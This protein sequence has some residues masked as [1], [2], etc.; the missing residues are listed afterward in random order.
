MPYVFSAGNLDGNQLNQG[1]ELS[2]TLP[3][4]LG[5]NPLGKYT[6]SPF[7]LLYP[8]PPKY[9]DLKRLGES[10]WSYQFSLETGYLATSGDTNSASFTEYG[11]WDEAPILNRYSFALENPQKA[12]YLN[13]FGGGVGRDDQFYQLSFGKYGSYDLTANYDSTPHVF[14]T[15]ARVLWDGAG[16]G[17]LTLPAGLIPGAGDPAELLS[18]FQSRSNSTLALER[19]RMS[20]AYRSTSFNNVELFANGDLEWRNGRRAFGGA[21]TYPELHQ[22][23]ET[24]E[25]VAYTTTDINLGLYYT[26]DKY[27]LNLAY[28][29]SFFRNE[30]D[31]LVW[32]NPGLSSFTP[33]PGIN[34]FPERGRFALAPDN[35][36]HHIKGDF[37]APIPVW[38]AR[39]TTTLSW[40][41][42]NQDDQL[43]APA[44]GAGIIGFPG[45]VIDRDLWNTREALSMQNAAA[46]IETFL[47]HIRLIT[48]PHRNLR[49]TGEF[50][51]QDQDDNTEYL[52]FNPLTGQ[53]GYPALDGGLGV[54]FP[55]NSGI[56]NPALPGSR[57]HY[58]NI[59]FEKDTLGFSIEADYR[60][61]SA[62]RLLARWEHQQD[63]YSY[64]EVNQ[65][66]DNVF[67]LQ[68]SHRDNNLGTL[69]VSY[70][71][72]DR[73]GDSYNSAP[74]DSFYSIS[75]P[76]YI[77]PFPGGNLPHTL[78]SLRKYDLADRDRHKLDVKV[79]VTLHERMDFIISGSYENED[80][81]AQ[82]GL[83]ESETATANL[84]GNYQLAA[85]ISAYA[86]YSWQSH[87]RD[88]AN[89]ND[90]GS[91]AADPSPGGPIYPLDNAWN[92]QIDEKNHSIGGGLN[93]TT[94]EV[95]FD[96]SYNY[97]Y[98][99]SEINYSYATPAAFRNLFSIQEA[100]NDFPDQTFRYHL[101]Q[102]DLRWYFR[103][104]MNLHLLYRYEREDNR[105][106]HYA[107][108]TAP[109]VGTDIYL[110]TVPEDYQ[111]HVIGI[112]LEANF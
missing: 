21:F 69:R 80:Y 54:F 31:S 34:I 50:R 16:T 9:P 27:Q 10:D 81:K 25:P 41:T 43:L 12:T 70:E 100:G 90:A 49:L 79:N 74:Y 60:L 44:I 93:G 48:N 73:R 47:T 95:S 110:A 28:S 97:L 23:T 63:D 104:N 55:G 1:V 18:A 83:R 78:S 15:D 3:D 65:V 101:L 77:T 33:P 107:G 29:G 13:G 26:G 109:V 19:D 75:L 105:D 82:H 30:I 32:E 37:A 61:L 14:S 51:Y 62:T 24:V 92:E 22:V 89:I 52:A 106:F 85:N 91:F 56:F 11:D 96:L 108:L 76:D 6:R 42:M 68:L 66:K 71:Y 57:V 111:A 40:H 4:T 102:A 35:E 64:R 7:G 39:F 59:P 2:Y 98:T 36:Y 94:D 17:N 103:E 99:A 20:I 5:L 67:R 88:V 45:N 84:E 46:E 38:N 72:A 112:M 87:M 58:R 86:F 8:E 53:F